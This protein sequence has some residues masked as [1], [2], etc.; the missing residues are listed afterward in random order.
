MGRRWGYLGY[1]P[2]LYPVQS[3]A[4]GW[5]VQGPRCFFFASVSFHNDS[6]RRAGGTAF[7]G[8][9]PV[10]VVYMAAGRMPGLS[11]SGM[12]NL[13][14]DGLVLWLWLW[15]WLKQAAG[16]GQCWALLATKP[17]ICGCLL[18]CTTL[19]HIYVFDIQLMIPLQNGRWV[20][21]Y[22]LVAV[23]F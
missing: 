9:P 22:S 8:P 2:R 3:R 1:L 17:G 20:P 5:M 14:L 23:C 13:D 11:F 10:S 7:F 15:L 19:A 21:I 6:G 4:D 12:D 16:C 18:A